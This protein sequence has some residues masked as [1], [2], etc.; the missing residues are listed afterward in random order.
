MGI[1]KNVHLF[2]TYHSVLSTMYQTR[3]APLN[4][5]HAH[6]FLLWLVL[7]MHGVAKVECVVILFKCLSVPCGGGQVLYFFFFS[8]RMPISLMEPEQSADAQGRICAVVGC[9]VFP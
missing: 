7:K 2:I 8:L 9:A 6:H 1:A 4:I 3:V 5:M